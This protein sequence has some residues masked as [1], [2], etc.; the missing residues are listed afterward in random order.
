MSKE[1]DKE[2]TPSSET[3]HSDKKKTP[4]TAD[5]LDAALDLKTPPEW[6]DENGQPDPKYYTHAEYYQMTKEK[7]MVELE[8]EIE[9]KNSRNTKKK[10]RN[11]WLKTILMLVFIGISVFVM[12]TITDSLSDGS[13]S[14]AEVIARSDWRFLLV[15]VGI[16]LLYMLL[17]SSKFSYLLKTSTGKMHLK[18]SIKTMYVGKYY[19]GITPLAT[20]GQP[21]QIYYLHKK[22]IPAGVAT[23]VPLVKFIV[24]TIVTC[25]G[26]VV[27]LALVPHVI[28]LDK[29]TYW[30]V[31]VAW[32]SLALNMLV[33]VAIVFVSLFPRIGRKMIAAIVSL[34]SKIRIVKHKYPTM[35]KYI[36]EIDEYRNAFKVLIR[37]WWKLIP[38]VILSIL[39][40]IVYVS[41]PFFATLAIAGPDVSDNLPLLYVQMACLCMVTFYSVC[42]VPTPG[43]SGAN[44]M[45]A[46]FVFTST[47]PSV[48]SLTG[49]MVLLWRFAIYY[50]FILS[51]IGISIFEIIRSAVRNKRAAKSEREQALQTQQAQEQQSDRA[52]QEAQA[53]QDPPEQAQEQTQEQPPDQEES[54]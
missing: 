8:K 51:G 6:T 30:F 9:E 43:N 48:M 17:E 25:I 39:T 31:V 41:V 2:E 4:V 21:F 16:I 3:T 27:L 49:W 52:P 47:L 20:G 37:H 19:D 34:L 23:S 36:T 32:V 44:E 10:Q 53:S 24:T 40:F 45:S 5:E 7:E 22:D 28:A 18:S 14:F 15:F 33:P 12:F 54:Q 38:L 29:A 35:K 11:W 42:W 46:A 50:V 26:G 1:K 13:A